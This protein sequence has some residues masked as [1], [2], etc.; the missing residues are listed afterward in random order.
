[1]RT[2]SIGLLLTTT[3]LQ[4][5]CSYAFSAEALPK[6]DS[7][8]PVARA[9]GI[10]SYSLRIRDSQFDHHPQTDAAL[11]KALVR[12]L[13]ETG[14]FSQVLR[15]DSDSID[16]AGGDLHLDAEVTLE[17]S[18]NALPH[19]IVSIL[20]LA[21][22]PMWARVRQTLR[23]S[24]RTANRLGGPYVVEDQQVIVIWLPLAVVTIPDVYYGAFT[25]EGSSMERL[26]RNLFR[27]LLAAARRDG[28]L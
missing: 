19:R 7:P 24:V 13:D 3:A 14:L 6:L 17:Q 9:L 21:T 11:E 22:V 26:D 4:V 15:N 10:A 28:L 25:G 2:L 8:T 27:N 20:T 5:S 12:A 16:L 23:G 18:G 1:M